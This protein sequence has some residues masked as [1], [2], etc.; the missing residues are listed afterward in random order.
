[1]DFLN[2]KI[3][4]T[5]IELSVRMKPHED[6]IQHLTQ[7]S[8][9]S[10]LSAALILAETGIDFSVF[11]SAKHLTS[12]AGLAPGSDQSAKKKKSIRVSKAGRF[13]KPLLV[14]CALAAIKDKKNRYFAIKYQRIKK[15][16][17][18]KRAIIAIARM[19]L[20]CI[21]NMVS[22]GESFHPSD[23]EEF[24]NPKPKPLLKLNDELAID[25]LRSQ[26]YDVSTLQKVM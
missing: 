12:W 13:L 1:M 19:M 22:K 3:L 24:R 8:G 10:N 16:R 25:F 5:E 6:L 15:R 26:G 21:Y 20:I 23:Y 7:I 17:G 18:H 14:Q 2:D 4:R 9:I 11:E